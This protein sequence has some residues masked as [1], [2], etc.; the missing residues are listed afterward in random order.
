MFPLRLSLF[1]LI[2]LAVFSMNNA[3]AEDWEMT[4][5]LVGS[6]DTGFAR[7][8]TISGNYAYVADGT[9]GLVI[10]NIEDPA[11]PT[12]V[13]SND[14]GG[15]ANSVTISGNY[16]Y[17]ADWNNGLVIL[18]IEDPANPTFVGSYDYTDASARGVTIS[19][20]YAYIADLYNG[21]VIINV[22]DPAN[23]T[24]AGSYETDDACGVTISGDYAYVADS[25]GD[26][27]LTIIHI[28]DPT[29]PTFV[30]SYDTDGRAFNVTISGNYA[31]VAD[32]TNGLV[33]VNIEDPTN[34]IFVGSYDTEGYAR[35]V[36]ISG[37]YAYVAD[38]GNG[39]VIL[40]IEDPSNVTFVGS[41]NT[42]YAM[43]VTISGNYVYVASDELVILEF[44]YVPIAVIDS[45]YPS[46]ARF[47]EEIFFNGSG[48]DSD[49][50]IVAYEW[51][52]S[53]DGFL[54]NEEDFSA[55]GF[56]VGNHYISFR[57]QDNSSRWSDD[58]STTLVVNPNY[59]PIAVIDSISPSPARFSDE[60]FFNGTSSDS[61]GTIVAYLWKSTIDGELSTEED[62]S[63]TGLSGGSHSIRFSVQDNDGG[64]SDYDSRTLVVYPNSLPI[65]VI[66]LISPSPARFSDEIFFNGSGED[67]DGTVVAYEWTS[68]ID[69]FLSD[70]EDFSI[71]GLSDGNHYISFGVQDNDGGWSDYDSTTL[72]VYPNSLPLAVIDSIYPSPAE[73]GTTVF[74]NGTSSDSDGTVVAYLWE[75]SIDGELSTEEDFT[76]TNL[77]IG[78]HTITFMVQD[79]DGAWSASL[80]GGGNVSIPG[81]SLWIY[82]S[83]VAI[84]GQDSTG[85][86]GVPL[87]FSGAGTDEDGTIAKYEWDFD[88][89]GVFEWS[90]T[91]NGLNTYIYNNE[92]TYTATLRVTDNDGFTDTDTVEVTISEKKIQ[93]DDDGNVTVTDAGED[94]EGIPG[95]GIIGAMISI[96]LIAR[97]RRR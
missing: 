3:E 96:G 86:P 22:E 10:L 66:D 7:D 94:D 84:A 43:D 70:E 48:E 18:D 35:S 13:G 73:K 87:Q 31:Y 71:T 44:G 16:A 83:P 55:T 30:G 68:S 37:N 58:D 41:V 57:V 45:I 81:I 63:T 50:I 23:P 34:P 59:F 53:I 77:S 80:E 42:D 2:F 69:G 20:N 6:Y 95:F 78:N 21:L 67:S 28:E 14:T 65:A 9:N 85:T 1:A 75:S 79:N 38:G 92:D 32:G 25:N 88:G 91:E 8:V 36:T 46:P 4:I 97:F 29:N 39:L 27:G 5:E 11:N 24:L 54:S 15:K 64:W 89:D 93:I 51:T 60:I 19:E 49:G 26:N 12:F 47:D 17:V 72:V 90:S 74:F 82:A 40:N 52:S 62:F 56:S 33:I 61:D 76:T